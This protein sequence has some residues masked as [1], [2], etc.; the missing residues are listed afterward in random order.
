MSTMEPIRSGLRLRVLEGAFHSE[1]HRLER[2]VISVGRSTPETVNSPSYLTFPEPTVSR[3]H[4]VMTWEV[5]AKAFL[6]HHRSQTNPTVLNNQVIKGPQLLKA[7]DRITLGRL[8]LLVEPETETGEELAAPAAT[9][10]VELS[11]NA[12]VEG[13]DR[14]FSA[15]VKEPVISLTFANDRT[16]AAV[17][18][19]QSPESW[20]EVRLPGSV[21]SALRFEID[22]A[23]ASCTVEAGPNNPSA[24]VRLSH[25]RSGTELRV[26]L[27]PAQRLPFAESDVLQHQGYRI[28]LGNPDRSPD[29]G[30]TL[31]Q[32]PSSGEPAQTSGR[33]LTLHFLNGPWKEGSISVP[34]HGAASVRLGPGDIGFRHP[35]P[36]ARLPQ[37]EISAQNGTARLLALAVDDDQFLE[38]DGDLVFA[39]ESVP[40]IGGSRLLVGDV[41]LLWTDGTESLYSAYRLRD[42]VASYPVRKASVRLGTAAHC[43]IM[44][45]QRELP[46]VIGRISF[47][48]GAP[49]YHHLDISASIRVDGEEASTGLSVPLHPGSLLELKPG[50]TLSFE[51]TPPKE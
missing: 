18:P 29:A 34:A 19:R 4:A 17:S 44:L 31:S 37:C 32:K 26:P 21:A 13:G 38:V 25:G 46:P 15:P 42:G 6:L 40:L 10:A 11:L 39:S 24:T 5:G 23:S 7:G 3:L 30:S 8:L 48:S 43:E 22:A 12:K 41:E 14:V 27:R 9:P 50:I 51:H 2:S 16:T 20:Q 35:F 28:W 49:I 36:L 1:T 47:E 33:R 45:P